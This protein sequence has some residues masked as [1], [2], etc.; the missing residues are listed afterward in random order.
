MTMRFVHLPGRPARYTSVAR[1]YDLVSAEPVYVRGR[2]LA[3]PLLHLAR[4]DTVLDVGCGT[5]LNFALLSEAVGPTG[6]IVGIDSSAEMLTQAGRR[7]RGR[8]GPDVVLRRGD[9]TS[10]QPDELLELI[11]GPVDAVLATYSLSLMSNWR[12]GFQLVYEVTRPLGRIAVVDMQ[13][14]TCRLA[15]PFA[16]IAMA[17]G[18]ADPAAR[19]W[20]A[21]E[22]TCTDVAT[23]TLPGAHIQV[24]VGT[25]PVLA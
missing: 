19:P 3:I 4:G 23:P 9:A 14:P 6:R 7:S 11:G 24:R 8:E 20:V 13:R 17:A 12:R 18:G 2:R 5:G 22:E 25:R 10:L 16:G 15:R 21:V 1:W